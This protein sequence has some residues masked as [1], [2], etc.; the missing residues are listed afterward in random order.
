MK[1]IL[2]TR[3]PL[4]IFILIIC[5]NA[6]HFRKQG[7]IIHTKLEAISFQMKHLAPKIISHLP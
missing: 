5:H 2:D 3:P 6:R 7:D 1:F 4:L